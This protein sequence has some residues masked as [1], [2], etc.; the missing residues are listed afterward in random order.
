MVRVLDLITVGGECLG[1]LA[2]HG[3]EVEMI[4]DFPTAEAIALEMGKPGF[5][6]KLSGAFND[7]TEESGFWLFLRQEGRYIASLATRYD[8]VGRESMR[9]Y[10]IRTMRR[11]YPH[12]SGETLI[13]VTEAMPPGFEGR[14]AYIG[15]LFVRPDARGSRQRLRHL[16]FLMHTCIASKWSVDWIYAMM[17]DRDVKAGFASQYGF[18]THLPGVARWASPPPEGRGD[19]EWLVAISAAQLDHMMRHYARS[20]E[21]L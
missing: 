14:L 16:M 12:E 18:T 9:D 15:E 7:F 1:A 8:N 17:R 11:H 2:E 21:S 10:F 5:T 19:S 6:A 3:I 13:E 4:T 20:L